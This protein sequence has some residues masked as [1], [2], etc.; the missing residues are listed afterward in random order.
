MEASM[1][2]ILGFMAFD[3]GCF[4]VGLHFAGVDATPA[5]KCGITITVI[6]KIVGLLLLISAFICLFATPKQLG[7]E[8]SIS[9]GT[10]LGLFAFIWWTLY[11]TLTKGGD[12]KPLAWF[13]FATLIV[14]SA[15]FAVN[16]LQLTAVP[17]LRHMM[18]E[19]SALM[20]AVVVLGI[21]LFLGLK[22]IWATGVK[23]GG[24]LLTLIGIYG[25][26]LT[27]ELMHNMIVMPLLA[28]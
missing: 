11:G 2:A 19:F 5:D 16:Y 25:F 13:A 21:F 15:F 23:A 6:Q 28:G 17:A 4:V 9:V 20:W 8:L 3:T 26:Y 14:L 24:I 12:F 22:G 1:P 7:P 27:Y 18:I 10:L